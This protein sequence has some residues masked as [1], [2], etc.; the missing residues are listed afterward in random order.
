MK[1]HFLGNYIFE[2]FFII[3][4]H[5]FFFHTHT[6]YNTVNKPKFCSGKMNSS[7]GAFY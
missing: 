5:S 2:F 4:K 6:L 1:D 7:K 3:R